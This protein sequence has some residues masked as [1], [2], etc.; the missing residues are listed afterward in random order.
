[1]AHRDPPL[2]IPQFPIGYEAGQRRQALG[3]F[4]EDILQ[5]LSHFAHRDG[6]LDWSLQQAR[7]SIA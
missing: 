6:P 1:M 3:I 4:C 5:S 2:S 7:E